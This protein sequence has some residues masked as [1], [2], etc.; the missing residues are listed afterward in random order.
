[1]LFFSEAEGKTVYSGNSNVDLNVVCI[2]KSE[3]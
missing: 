3:I 2:I 1:M